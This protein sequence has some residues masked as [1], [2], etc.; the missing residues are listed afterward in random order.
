[1]KILYLPVLENDILAY[2]LPKCSNQML[3]HDIMWL[4]VICVF[5]CFHIF[6]CI[7]LLK[8]LDRKI[9]NVTCQCFV[10]VH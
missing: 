6:S 4:C 8:V 3:I 9:Q 5:V 10:T 7:S 1:M 2:L